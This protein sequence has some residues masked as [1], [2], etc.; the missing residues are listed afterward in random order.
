MLSG[1]GHVLHLELLLVIFSGLFPLLL[2]TPSPRPRPSLS[3]SAI[4]RKGSKAARTLSRAAV[5]P[6]P[7][8]EQGGAK[9]GA[10]A[11]FCWS[12]GR[13]RSVTQLGC[14]KAYGASPITTVRAGGQPTEQRKSRYCYSLGTKRS[15]RWPQPHGRSTLS[16]FL[17]LQTRAMES[18]GQCF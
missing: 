12:G 1:E 17:V 13:G 2:S 15:G 16:V 9:Y 11:C 3:L 4:D 18:G 5:S 10:T 8:S 7:S 14:N 6:F